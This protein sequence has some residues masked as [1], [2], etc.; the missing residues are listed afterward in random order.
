MIIFRSLAMMLFGPGSQLTTYAEEQKKRGRKTDTRT[1]KRVAQSFHPYRFQVA[2]VL[3]AILLTTLLGLVN[4]ILIAHV[5]D[6]AILKNDK[7]LLLIYVGI[8]VAVPVVSG[9]IGVGQ[10]YLNNKVGQ[11]V[12]ADFRNQLYQH[13]QS[14]PL[15]FFTGIRTGEIQS[16]LSNDVSGVQGVVTNTVTN[17]VANLSMVLSTILAMLVISPLLTL[18]SLGLL[19]LFLWLT[20][21]VGKIRRE[22]SKETQKSLA[23]LT[24]LLQETL[25]VSGILLVKVSGRQKYAQDQFRQENEKLTDL[26]MRQIVV[27]RWFFMTI[28]IFFAVMPALV[29]LVAGI[30]IIERA[31]VLG[32]TL[33][34][35]TII[36]FTALQGRL[37]F[38]ISQLLTMQVEIQGALAL[39]DRIFEYL[40]LPIEIQD[41]PGALLLRPEEIHGEV[42]F[43]N[44]SFRYKNDAY[45]ILK[46]ING[47]DKQGQGKKKAPVFPRW[48]ATPPAPKE[49]LPRVLKNISFT[50]KPGQLVALVGPSGAGKTTIT[51]MLPRLYDVESGAVEIDGI[52]VK[53]I[54]QCSLGELIGVVTQ[55]TYL[56]HASV[57]ENLLYTRPDAT[58]EEMVFA[59]QAAAIH[60]RIMELEDGYDTIVGERGYK[61]SGGEKQRIAIARVIL[62]NPRILILD[63][64]TSSLDTH[65]ERLVQSSLET[66]MR[67]RTTL[68]IAHR[69][70]TILAADVIL[71]VNN[72][73]IVEGGTHAQLLALNG[74]YAQLYYEQFSRV[75][76]A[77][78]VGGGQAQGAVPT[79]FVG[80][81][82]RRA[83]GAV[84][85]RWELP[86]GGGQAQAAVPT[87][88]VPEA[89][90][91]ETGITYQDLMKAMRIEEVRRNTTSFMSGALSAEQIVPVF[92]TDTPYL[93]AL[94]ALAKKKKMPNLQALEALSKQEKTPLI[95]ESTDHTT[96]S[97]PVLSTRYLSPIARDIFKPASREGG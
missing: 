11:R 87:A 53:D 39:F 42:T 1:V 25:S 92:E 52:N 67:G 55:E 13:L 62:K 19:P 16:R 96:S 78:A 82:G 21:K 44:V 30:Q 85:T 22:T 93:Q 81:D 83:Q 51:Y 73:S 4:P 43:R 20:Y 40:D 10:N 90:T 3:A 54:A 72:G 65:S 61:L 59:A 66:V 49:E 79:A 91:P 76:Q 88:F 46:D 47:H 6:D 94:E 45:D 38:P 64:A 58:E 7:T 9:F 56:F 34:L 75:P 31:E 70:S 63:E 48:N 27:G 68:A 37:F 23:S 24:G 28:G 33:S 80:S 50:I 17:L 8:M 29:Y 35:G 32:G 60:D 5:F 57:R 89:E 2:L 71:V 15:S 26:A 12:M 84:P 74:L 36:A 86:V 97:I 95:Q 14:M 41:K 77:E 69:L 18:I